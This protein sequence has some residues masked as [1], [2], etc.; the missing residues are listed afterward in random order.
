MKLKVFSVAD[1]GKALV[2]LPKNT[3]IKIGQFIYLMNFTKKNKK[4]LDI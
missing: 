1:N 4:S 3:N 2:A